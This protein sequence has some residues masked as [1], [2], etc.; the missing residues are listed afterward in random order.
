MAG[1]YAVYHQTQEGDYTALGGKNYKAGKAFHIYRPRIEDATGASCWGELNIDVKAGLLT[2]TIPQ[3]WLDQAVYP[4]R[5]AAGLTFGY[6][7]IGG[8][9]TTPAICLTGARHTPSPVVTV[10]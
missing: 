10:L 3:D 1:S 5:H 4:V 9:L 6:T 2:V 7:S 8:A